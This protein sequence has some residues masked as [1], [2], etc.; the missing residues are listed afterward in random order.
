MNKKDLIIVALATFCLTST[1]FMI[2]PSR[3]SIP[4]DPWADVSGPT[5]GTAD[6][7]INMRDVNY[8]LQMFGTSGST[9]KDVNV[10][11]L[12]YGLYYGTINVSYTGGYSGNIVV[13]CGGYSRLSLLMRPT[14]VSMFGGSAGGDAM[15][16]SLLYIYWAETDLSAGNPLPYSR[17]TVNGA[18]NITVPSTKWWFPPFCIGSSYMTEIKST[19]ANLVFVSNWTTIMPASWYV[20]LDCC[21]YLRNE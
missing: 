9:T 16:L 1:V 7:T 5:Q 13:F 11:N 12:P 6:G 8:L 20:T 17:E 15:A 2:L 14:A 3:S 19:Y 18:F 21:V 4:Y 10:T